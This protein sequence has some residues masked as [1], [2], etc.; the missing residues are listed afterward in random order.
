MK[1]LKVYP[2]NYPEIVKAFPYIKGRHGMVFAWHSVIYNPSGCTLPPDVIAHEEVHCSRQYRDVTLWW[3]M[4]LVN[5]AFRLQEE[6]LAYRAQITF[7]KE[8]YRAKN[9]KAIIDR[10]VDSLAGK[11]YGSLVTKDEARCLLLS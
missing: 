10:C 3:D 9:G 11:M 7:V 8:H 4:Y 5:P 6:V 2:P 1:I